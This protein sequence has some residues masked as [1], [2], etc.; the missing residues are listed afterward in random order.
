[1]KQKVFLLN[2]PPRSGKDFIAKEV[3]NSTRLKV[4]HRQFKE[5][6]FELVFA[7][8]DISPSMW[9]SR[10]ERPTKGS[11]PDGWTPEQE[12]MKDVPWIEL[13]F[14]PKTGNFFSQREYMIYV[15]EDIMKPLHGNEYFAKCAVF[16]I[17]DS[18]APYS[19]F[20]DGGF[21]EEVDVLRYYESIDLKVIAL[22][23]E[24]CSFEG[25]SRKYLDNPDYTVYNN[26]SKKEIINKVKEIMFL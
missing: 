5:K 13:P 26:G 9:F 25:D 1:M 7:M 24:G 10:Y 3:I 17:L 19:I 12:W 11:F 15:S 6:L 21:E 2:G 14:N 4:R 20:T 8:T 23:R 16:K 22:Y 18:G